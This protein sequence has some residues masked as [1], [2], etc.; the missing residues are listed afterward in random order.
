[1]LLTVAPICTCIEKTKIRL[2]AVPDSAE[3]RL[4]PVPDCAE[5]KKNRNICF[6]AQ[7]FAKS[8]GLVNKPDTNSW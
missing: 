3:L 4:S 6:N 7:K 1:M 8:L 2:N 5:S